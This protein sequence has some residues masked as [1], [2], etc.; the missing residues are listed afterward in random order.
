MSCCAKSC[1]NSV[2]NPSD[3]PETRLRGELNTFF[4]N[5]STRFSVISAPKLRKL[6][7]KCKTGEGLGI[8]NAPRLCL[9]GLLSRSLQKLKFSPSSQRFS[10]PNFT[11]GNTPYHPQ[12]SSGEL[13]VEFGEF[14]RN[15][16]G[17]LRV[18]GQCV[19]V[20]VD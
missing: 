6:G 4:I 18:G 7:E 17:F 16:R 11:W 12:W 1:D 15:P 5:P 19:D 10:T 8:W 13:V 20:C 14:L 2:K 9:C 3:Y